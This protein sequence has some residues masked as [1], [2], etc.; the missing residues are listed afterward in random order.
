MNSDHDSGCLSYTSCC[1][2]RRKV[3]KVQEIVDKPL[4]CVHYRSGWTIHQLNLH[5]DSLSLETN[6]AP[7]FVPTTSRYAFEATKKTID[8]LKGAAG[9][10][11]VPLVKEVLD[12]GLAMITTCEASKR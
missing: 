4:V 10:V 3:K 8:I 11:G 7:S 9:S 2:K 12:V 1:H 6:E 5:H